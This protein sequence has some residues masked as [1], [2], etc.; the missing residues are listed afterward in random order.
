MLVRHLCCVIALGFLLVGGCTRKPPQ[1]APGLVWQEIPKDV[2][3]AD[4]AAAFRVERTDGKSLELPEDRNIFARDDRESLVLYRIDAQGLARRSFTLSEN[5]LIGEFLVGEHYIV[6]APLQPWVINKYILLC[7]IKAIVTRL[8]RAIIDPL[9]LVILCPSEPY[10]ADRLLVDFPE[11]Q[12]FTDVLPREEL[13]RIEIGPIPDDAFAGQPAPPLGLGFDN[14][15]DQCVGR[16]WDVVLIPDCRPV[17]VPVLCWE[18][19]GPG[20]NTLGQV[21]NITD[22]EVVGAIHAVAP[23]P[24]DPDIAYVGAV[25]GGIWRTG[26]AMSASPIWTRQ[27]D[28]EE[29]LSIGALEFDP[30]DTI[31]L[32]LVAGFGRF[33]SFLRRGG[34]RAGLLRTTNG[35]HWT[36]IDGGGTLDGLNVS[37]VAPRGSTIVLSADAADGFGNREGVWRSINTGGE[38]TQ[39]S[40]ARD[41]DLPAGASFDLASDPGD[42]ERLFTN[43]GRRGLFRS[44]DTGETWIKV[45]DAT[46][47]ALIAA[48]S[49]VEIS[50]GESVFVAIVDNGRFN[51]RLSG[52]FRSTTDGDTWTSMGV[53]TTADGGLH[54][55]GQG[56]LHLSIAADP[57]NGD[58]VYV[59]GDRQARPFTGFPNA[60]GAMDYS[61]ILFRGDASLPPASRWMPLT[62]TG[63]SSNSSPHADSRDMDVAANGMLIE[64]DDGGIYRRTT[65]RLISGDWFSMNGDIQTTEFHD[66]DWDANV[67]IIVGGAQDTGS[68][69]QQA[70]TNLTW[71]SIS[72]ADGGD[73]AVD[74]TSTPGMSVRYSSNQRLGGFRRRTYDAANVFQSQVFPNLT[75]LNAGARV[76]A[77]FYTPIELN[78]VD[79][80]RLII[81]ADNSVYESL[82]QGDTV[83]EIGP[84]IRVNGLGSDPIAYGGT[85]N[86]DMLYVGSG[87]QVFVRTAAPPAVLI[88]SAAYNG[89]VVVD[90]GIARHDPDTAFVADSDQVFRTTNAGASWPD[91]S[92]NLGELNAGPIRSLVLTDVAVVVGTDTGVFSASAPAF[93]TWSRLGECLPTV[94]V[95]DLSFDATDRILVAG[96]LGR[97]AWILW[98]N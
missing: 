85:G 19:R 42:R 57:T 56:E 83:T 26:N 29:S 68:P 88:A 48:S 15:C 36:A 80:T 52:V 61:G 13:R 32:T 98:L 62:H 27:T 7:W 76:R 44:E 9:C 84:G 40:G 65:P 90:I 86:P 71:E 2:L 77:Q 30:T 96:T 58:I 89:G 24:S 59:G 82:D 64:T 33:S 69:Q 70:T 16:D 50:V 5:K 67:N 87:A 3:V 60:I 53:P 18:A 72:T 8:D 43:A 78:N 38:W 54:P 39:I 46:M 74:D 11:L 63:T 10:F 37:G 73:V 49:N 21:E 23:H 79:Q 45:S 4:T 92:G 14:I 51:K 41:S 75:V 47:D 12:Q 25:N 28:D 66:S 34:G 1:P 97:G 95:Y 81:G 20:P 91:V 31:N 93:N 94:P 55:G 22:R 6:H 35:T 17:I